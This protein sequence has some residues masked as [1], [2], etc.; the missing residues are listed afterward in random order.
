MKTFRNVAIK[1]KFIRS[2][3]LRINLTYCVRLCP[4]LL[5]PSPSAPSGKKFKTWEELPRGEA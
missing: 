5:R 4:R 2:E 3:I 1:A